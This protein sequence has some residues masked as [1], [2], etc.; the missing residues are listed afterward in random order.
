MKTTQIILILIFLNIIS[1]SNSYKE[2]L[3]CKDYQGNYVDWYVVFLFPNSTH[4]QKKL[5]YAYYDSSLQD[6]KYFDY[7]EEEFPPN[8]VTEYAINAIASSD[9]VNYFFWNDDKTCKDDEESKSASS[10]KAHAKGSL[11]MDSQNSVFLLHSLPRFP[12]RMLSGDVLREMPSNAGSY[13]QHFICISTNEN[14]GYKLAEILNYI[15]ISNNR[16]VSKD[17]VNLTPNPWISKLITNKLNS[18]YPW[19][20]TEKIESL[21]GEEFTI[22]YK[23]YKHTVIPFDSTLR[24]YYQDD[25]YVRSWTRPEIAPKICD[26]TEYSIM[27]VLNVKFGNFQY[28]EG[29]EHSKW[30]VSKNKNICCFSDINHTESQAK[31]GGSI[32]CFVNE[33]LAKIMRNAIIE[34]DTCPEKPKPKPEAGSLYSISVSYIFIILYFM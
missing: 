3:K 31:R 14:T 8:K 19:F 10:S 11:I 7:K 32:F 22:F 26:F 25:F 29:A 20:G 12:T 13:G 16:G 17:M 24:Q 33:K 27:N 9:S 21:A 1:N 5:S 30:A 2:Q 4:P 6:L 34:A 23:N 15:N 28:V 18:S